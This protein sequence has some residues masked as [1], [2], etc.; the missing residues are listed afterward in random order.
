L[1]KKIADSEVRVYRPLK[2]ETVG[3]A[4]PVLRIILD[5][6]EQVIAESGAMMT[7]KGVRMKTINLDIDSTHNPIKAAFKAILRKIFT[8]E[9]VFHNLFEGPGEVWL[10]PSLPG[11]IE[12]LKLKN[13]CWILQ[14][15]SYLAHYGNV[16]LGLAFKAKLALL[17][18]G[19]LKTDLV[20][21]KVCGEGG[22]WLSSYGDIVEYKV[23]EGEEVIVDNMHFVALPED[24]RWKVVKVG[25]LKEFMFSGEGY[26]VK[27]KG[28]TKVLLQT[29]I[30]PP[31]AS[32]IA[33]FMPSRFAEMIVRLRT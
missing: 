5:E 17:G 10:S 23:A 12:Y 27:V 31:L 28:P 30:L 9:T 15:Y 22:V 1:I 2:W 21:L 33:R 32:A 29:R 11:N 14:D 8:G 6:G 16:D 24:A 20:W 26:V 18:M 13:K 7:M 4:Y 25:E 19:L 3:T